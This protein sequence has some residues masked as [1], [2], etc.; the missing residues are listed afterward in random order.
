MTHTHRGAAAAAV[1]GS[2]RRGR[3]EGTGGPADPS[4]GAAMAAASAAAGRVPRAMVAMPSARPR[5]LRSDGG[6]GAGALGFSASAPFGRGGLAR[7]D[8]ARVGQGAPTTPVR[9]LPVA[10]FGSRKKPTQFKR[11]SG[12]TKLKAAPARPTKFGSGT[13]KLK[14]APKTKA[15]PKAKPKS[16][17]ASTNK[18]RPTAKPK[19]TRKLKALSKPKPRKA[20][21][22]R[23]A[24]PAAR[25]APSIAV[26]PVKANVCI[27]E[28]VGE[29]VDGLCAPAC[30][31]QA[32]RH[33]EIQGE[34]KAKEAQAAGAARQE[35][36]HH[37]EKGRR[38]FGRARP[39]GA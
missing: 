37:L 7:T 15:K 28:L 2:V 24:P 32:D 22:K 18:F 6:S 29:F 3:G 8:Y 23:C 26:A 14:G 33:V 31:T 10:L 9:A 25:R 27:R 19:A 1:V 30:L 5:L 13:A 11:G 34:A 38:R 35:E 36:A 12:T 21:P 39:D 20:A 17:P 16:K 4:R